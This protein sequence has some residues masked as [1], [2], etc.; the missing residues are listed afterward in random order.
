MSFYIC[1]VS[2]YFK[3]FVYFVVR[4][5]QRISNHAQRIR[6]LFYSLGMNPILMQFTNCLVYFFFKINNVIPASLS[7]GFW[8]KFLLFL[9]SW[10]KYWIIS[11][12]RKVLQF[13]L[14][15][16]RHMRC[17]KNW[18]RRHVARK[19]LQEKFGFVGT[20][21]EKIGFVGTLIE[22]TLVVQLV[23]VNPTLSW[24]KSKFAY[25]CFQSESKYNIC[26]ITE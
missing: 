23:I 26:Q 18:L 8:I 10:Q 12:F 1:K 25:L 22:L 13:P 9:C 3:E 15:V 4:E 2:S 21:Q 16:S 7:K 11:S 17:T 24:W 19:E 20:L 5:F 6:N 14:A